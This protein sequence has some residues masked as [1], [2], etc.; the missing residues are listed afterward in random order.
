MRLLEFFGKTRLDLKGKK[1]DEDLVNKNKF[2]SDEISDELYWFILDH[3]KLHKEH[4]MPI[5]REIYS[6]YKKKQF[7]KE[8]YLKKWMPMVNKGC[9]EFYKHKKMQGDPNDI[10]TVEMRKDLCHKLS[11]QHYE[12]IIKG[13]YR[14]G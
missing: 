14:L 10:F 3:D 1:Q 5:A 8:N 11:D 2:S 9:L 7:N 6:N 4:F 13:E 12:D